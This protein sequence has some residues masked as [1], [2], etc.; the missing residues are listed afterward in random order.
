[1]RRLP[2][3][4]QRRAAWLMAEMP[5]ARYSFVGAMTGSGRGRIAGGLLAERAVFMGIAGAVVL[6]LVAST[7]RLVCSR[8]S[9]VGCTSRF[10]DSVLPFAAAGFVAGVTLGALVPLVRWRVLSPLPGLI[11]SAE[12]YVVVLRWTGVWPF[13]EPEGFALAAVG[14]LACPLLSIEEW[15]RMYRERANFRRSLRATRERL[16]A[17][18]ASK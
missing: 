6:A 10:L 1:M 8:G 13:H 7:I 11:A 18:H 16:R 2:P 9:A 12:V 17:W 14:L 3:P 5:A 15:N 4:I